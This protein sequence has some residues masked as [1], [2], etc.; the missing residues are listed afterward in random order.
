VIGLYRALLWLLLP[1]ALLRLW[2]R[3]RH[4]P[5]YRRQ[6]AERLGWFKG[7]PN[8][9]TQAALSSPGPSRV[10]WLHAVS[11]GETHASQPLVEALMV[12][13]P[14][15]DIVLT[16]ATPTGRATGRQLFGDRV[17]QAYLPWDYGFAVRGFFRHF[18]PALGILM[19]TELWPELLR[20]ARISGVPVA[21]V[22]G[23]LSARSAARYRWLGSLTGRMLAGLCAV[24]AQGQADADR[25]QSLGARRVCVTGNLKFDVGLP[26]SL[27]ALGQQI[28]RQLA[29]RP[30][31]LAAST[32]EGEEALMLQTHRQL[33]A[34]GALLVLVPRHPQ[35]FE[36]VAR[37]IEQAGFR[38]QR[39]SAGVLPDAA[40]EVWL[41]DS[42]GE[43]ALWYAMA[44]VAV[45][46]GSV[47]P[48]GGQNL[49]E[50]LSAGCPVIVGPHT[51]NFATASEQA[52]ATGA[53]C[54]VHDRQEMSG[55][56]A[57]LLQSTELRSAMAIAGK[58]LIAQQRGATART[59]DMLATCLP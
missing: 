25:L 51:W 22:N 3:G 23:R 18:Q 10:I 14:D 26:A 28:K 12:R 21:L 57:E 31:W 13:F 9:V 45:M 35:R 41:G 36:A 24:G 2:W 30:V 16:H 4:E 7:A 32:R 37:Q 58:Q 19:E 44:D 33:S 17:I 39:R 59:L 42:M 50:P 43:M 49:I 1:V 5:G 48:F 40:C 29:A 38:Y 53:A 6:W 27:L 47:L 15:A 20:Q 8:H 54:L 56:L 46:G 52:V 55:K 34:M 11:V